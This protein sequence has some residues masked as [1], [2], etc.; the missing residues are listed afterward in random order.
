MDENKKIVI[1]L[2]QTD[3]KAFDNPIQTSAKENFKKLMVSF[4]RTIE[5]TENTN[6]NCQIDRVHNTILINGKRGMGKTSFILSVQKDKELAEQFKKICS[7]CIIDPTLIETKE[8]VLLNIITLIKEKV[9]NY[10]RE[11]ECK[12]NHTSD[13][14]NWKES[15]KKLAGG[16]SMLDGVGKNHLQEDMWDSPEL[17]LENGLSNS[18]QGY[19]LEK[20]FHK[21]IDISLKILDKEAFFLILDD[22]DTSLDK[23]RDI[24][25]VLRKYLT[26]RKLIIAML[27]DIDLYSILV[28]QL[29][30][31][32]MDP[33]KILKDYEG[34]NK[35]LDQIEHLEEQYLVKVLKPENRIDLKNLFD[36]KENLAINSENNTLSIF[37]KDMLDNVYLTKN[38]RYAHDYEQ[39]LLAQS[40]RSV[41]QI[42]QSWE[43]NGLSK[44][45]EFIDSIKH[46]FYTTLKKKLE[47]YNL[48]EIP[49][50]E[51][52]L[53][54]LSIYILREG[55]SRDNHLKL[56]PEFSKDEDNIAMLYINAMA[57][58]L[59][60][61]SD[62]LAYFIKVGYTLERY[63]SL[64]QN[65]DI[66][67]FSKF[68]DHIAL[69]SNEL[70][71]K[72]SKKLLTTFKIDSNTHS[73]N[74][75]FF[76]NLSLSKNNLSSISSKDNL[77][78][79]LSG[80]YNPKS[81]TYNILS[82]FNLLGLLSDISDSNN[83]EDILVRN[84]LLRD[85]YLYD[86]SE[87]G[88]LKKDE[89]SENGK[90][91][92]DIFDI[93]VE[94][95]EALI[96]WTKN[97]K[98]ITQKLDIADLS[99]IWIRLVYSINE[100]ES[101]SENKNK[102]YFELI[103]LYIAAFLNAVYIHCEQKKGKLFVNIKNPS[104]KPK[105]FYDK[106]QEYADV[107][108]EKNYTLFDYL[109]ECPIF[110]GFD[111]YFESLK[112]IKLEDKFKPI[113]KKDFSKLKFEDQ[114][115]ILKKV[116]EKYVK[117]KESTTE[118]VI[119]QYILMNEREKNLVVEQIRKEILKEG[120]QKGFTKGM[121]TDF[122]NSL[123]IH[124]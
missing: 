42:L 61:P 31:E 63:K 28:R 23:G 76:G 78:L 122:I 52:F 119:S 21:F 17:I 9:D 66:N 124:Q 33:K 120:Y 81:G 19:S 54:L 7:F 2:S 30:W 40:T 62:Y 108:E 64:Y 113:I 11:Y 5:N 115:K 86:Q 13:Y 68:I 71:S 32:K 103:E 3:T 110:K 112:R 105:F 91:D 106:L 8:H 34:K 83:V 12:N 45:K 89:P 118:I 65:E 39:T 111:K 27:G 72:I 70:T 116:F 35:Y 37:V 49:Q 18:K 121:F 109:L 4:L 123:N 38:S 90:K 20:N 102:N 117:I 74:Q 75:I 14:Q 36:L 98:K 25:E 114:N 87:S 93:S 69:D 26:S 48:L 46:T 60:E 44:R 58:F 6:E 100:I 101:R 88:I 22:I 1:D 51:Q 56:T 97:S 85:F 82:I 24:L 92:E 10:L 77:A 84:N 94:L 50:R 107:I 95:K 15:L 16:L 96:E 43:K 47:P 29:Q 73:S 79:L 57:N 41:L 80:A 67:N 99:K 55:I 53:N 104:I 59:L